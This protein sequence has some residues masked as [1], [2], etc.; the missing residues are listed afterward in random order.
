MP[1]HCHVST[2]RV[3]QVPVDG[4]RRINVLEKTRDVRRI[5]V[6]HDKGPT[7]EIS[8]IQPL[9]IGGDPSQSDFIIRITD[10]DFVGL[11]SL[12]THVA[13]VSYTWTLASINDRARSKQRLKR[14]HSCVEIVGRPIVRD[15][16]MNM[17]GEGLT[18]Q[19]IELLTN[20][21]CTVLDRNDD[22]NLVFWIHR[23]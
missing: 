1:A 12:E 23:R 9:G 19:C 3:G 8:L 6:S 15:D 4:R 21:V 10:H 11:R 5:D 16:Q 17:S 22:R 18:R 7:G 13:T 2:N 14:A 20:G